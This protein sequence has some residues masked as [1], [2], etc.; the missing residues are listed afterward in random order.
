MLTDLR[1]MTKYFIK[2]GTECERRGADVADQWDKFITTI[3]VFYNEED[4][5]FHGMS[6]M[7]FNLPLEAAPYILLLSNIGYV[8]RIDD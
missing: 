5:H 7:S 8:E 2:A 3:D 4:V 6:L 1:S